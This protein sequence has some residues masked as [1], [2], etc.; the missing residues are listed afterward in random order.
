MTIELDATG[1]D[2]LSALIDRLS[3]RVTALD[4]HRLAPG[5]RMRASGETTTFHYI[6]EGSVVA[7]RGEV[8]R[9]SVAGDVLL[10]LRGGEHELRAETESRVLSGTMVLDSVAG[11][12]LDRHLPELL[13][14]CGLILRDPLM[15]MMLEGM[16]RES[17]ARRL[18]SSSLVS[19]LAN[20]VA[21]SAIRGWI[22]NGCG[23]E[24]ADWL[25]AL[26]DPDVA[27]AL[28]AIHADPGSAWTVASLARVARSS[29]SLF[30]ERFRT[31]VGEPPLRYL[32]RVR[33]ERA[34]ELLDRGA[35]VGQAATSLGY[36]SDVAF[37]RAFR[38]HVGSSP[39][40]WRRSSRS[41]PA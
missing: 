26:R 29:R 25:I 41:I 24:A 23:D 11:S 34:M 3:W 38:R 36:G 37:S 39:S 15:V 20:V 31:T 13:V 19:R 4:R 27:L 9:P 6:A 17:S 7:S 12:P 1:T 21:A 14:A 40:Q 8:T 16:E 32:S 35:S 30:S 10:L 2:P 28:E 33:M 5:Q 18:G 22:E